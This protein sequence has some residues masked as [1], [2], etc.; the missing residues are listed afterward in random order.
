MVQEIEDILLLK[1]MDTESCMGTV[2]RVWKKCLGNWLEA[3][4]LGFIYQPTLS[5][6]QDSSIFRSN[7][8]PW[9]SVW[10]SLDVIKGSYILR[11]AGM[12]SSLKTQEANP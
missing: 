11:D 6:D 10:V 3:F 7:T 2:P 9:K 8:I 1:E 12:N 5:F 4:G